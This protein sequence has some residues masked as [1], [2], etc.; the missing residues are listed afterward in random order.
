MCSSDLA[1]L[2]A[3]REIIGKLSALTTDGS[4]KA[5]ALDAM[6]ELQN[7]WNQTGHVPFREKDKLFEAYR[8]ALD[9]VRRHF[10][11]AERGARREKF[12]RDIEALEGDGDKLFRERDRMMRIVEARRA[13]LRTYQNNLGFLTSKSKSGDSLVRDMERRIERLQADIDELLEK[14]KVLD[15][16]IPR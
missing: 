16:R 8:D 14:V 7:Q 13:E 1:N 5:Q 11:L 15:A 6:R 9:A 4:E 2:K 10:D 3:K 12:S